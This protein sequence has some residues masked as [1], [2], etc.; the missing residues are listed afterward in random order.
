MAIQEPFQVGLICMFGKHSATEL[1]PQP[2]G[3]FIIYKD[4]YIDNRNK[5]QW[6]QAHVHYLS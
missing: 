5:Q 3:C 4:T 2:Q 6:Q 1:Q